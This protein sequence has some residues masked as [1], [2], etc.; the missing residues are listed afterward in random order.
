MK[1]NE[2]DSRRRH[3]LCLSDY[4]RPVPVAH[5][6][7]IDEPRIVVWEKRKGAAASRTFVARFNIDLPLDNYTTLSGGQHQL[8]AI[9]GS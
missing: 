6:G 9:C 5:M 7:N 3:R 4:Q 1:I 8:C 2:T